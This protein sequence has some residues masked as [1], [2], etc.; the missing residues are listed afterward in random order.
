MSYGMQ[1]PSRNASYTIGATSTLISQRMP[2]GLRKVIVVTNTSTGGE[3]ITLS[4]G[5]QAAAGAGI[6]LS[7]GGSWNESQDNTFM[8]TSDEIWC[9]G[10]GAGAKVAI[11]ERMNI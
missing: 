6:I 4:I 7:S 3:T 9:I 8:V 2:E 1:E 5:Q 10:S 11:Y